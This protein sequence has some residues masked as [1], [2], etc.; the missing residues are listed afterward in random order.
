MGGI[1]REPLFGYILRLQGSL[2]PGAGPGFYMNSRFPRHKSK[3]GRKFTMLKRLIILLV[4]V[5]L[6]SSV[7]A[8]RF[9]KQDKSYGSR[10]NRWESSFLMGYQNS[11][12]KDF[13]GG[14]S[15]DIDKKFGWG[16]TIGYNWTAKLNT[17]YKLFI[18][19]P[20]YSATIIPENPEIGPQTIDYTMSKYSH[21][22]NATYNFMDR[23][24]TPFVQAGLGFITLDSNIVDQ[25]PTTGCWWDPW[26]GWV[27]NTTWST[28][29]KTGFSYNV[30][31][32]LRWDVNNAMFVRGSYNK[33][34][35]S[36]DNGTLSFDI[37]S[38][39][40]GLMF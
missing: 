38:F 16:I 35:I 25:P 1:E 30:G 8:Q 28:Y 37:L 20:N 33:E 31:L 40:G 23:P 14:A 32:G 18:T 34:W 5:S 3:N 6:S 2:R 21:Q 19:K 27:C 4:L 12:S 26:W 7:F 17:A 29:S 36:V 13:E 11:T 24:F 22:F 15:L 10:N 9:N 39:E